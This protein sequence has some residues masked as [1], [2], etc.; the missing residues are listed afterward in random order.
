MLPIATSAEMRSC[1][2]IAIE[3]FSISG[4]VLMEN[5]S[6]GVVNAIVS[7]Y[8]VVRGR[9]IYV[10]CGKGNNGGDGFALARHLYNLNA[11]VFVF[12]LSEPEKLTGDA[13]RNFE[14]IKKIRD[15]RTEGEIFEIT[16]I[17]SITELRKFPRPDLIVDA[18]FGTGFKGGVRDLFL[19]VIQ[20]I[21][22][23]GVFTVSI[24]IPSGV[25]AD[26]GE[27]TNIAV[28]ADVTATMGLI[29]RGLILNQGRVKSGKVYVV[30]IGVPK[31]IYENSGIK[32]FLIEQLDVK[33]KLPERPFNAH[34]YSCGK[35]FAMGGSPGL[36]GAA[37]MSALS[38][39]KVGAGVVV[40]G[41]PESLNPVLEEKLTEVMTVP[42]PE[43]EAHTIGWKSLQLVDK[44]Y[45]WADVL[46]LGPGLSKEVNTQQVIL[47]IIGKID[48][49][50]VIDADGLSALAGNL[51]ILKNLEGE[52]VL[53]PHLGEFSR[54]TGVNPFRIEANRVELARDFA[55]KY[56]VVLVLKGA[57]TVIAD[58]DGNVYINPTGNPGMA[59]AGSGD[60]LTG[61][62]AGFMAQ[63]LSAVDSAI[64]GV[65]I[66]GLAGDMAREKLGEL[67]MMAMDILNFLPDAI[68][69]VE[70]GNR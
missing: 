45:E 14:I 41:V 34:K 44:Y 53:T 65:Y 51:G 30:D 22:E 19:K 37:A 35:I 18:I 62:I 11:N 38:A 8:G 26:T 66:H 61:I 50:A 68:L 6:R 60:V 56:N 42:L 69:K 43:T 13:R 59:T 32:T 4:L 25:N 17:K 27:V 33:E 70:K 9:N 63:G 3:K 58:P 29:K 23:Q 31:F 46:I 1:D 67:S 24:D 12:I 48:K 21:N 52:I 40:L 47:H 16:R 2:Q 36:T 28:N 57:P 15:E 64:C 7:E 55:V 20:W 10:F 54:L 39:M 49:K 5:A